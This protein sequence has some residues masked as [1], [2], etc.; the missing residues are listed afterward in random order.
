MSEQ[1][2]SPLN[3][4]IEIKSDA[5]S[6]HNVNYVGKINLRV[7]EIDSDLRNKISDFLGYELPFNN[8]VSGDN[9]T[10]TLWLG[11]NEYLILCED[12]EKF[13][14]IN[15]LRSNL[16][17]DFFA[18]TDVSDYYLTM[19]L[20]GQN[21]IDVL[22]KSCSLDFKLNVSEKDTCAQTYINKATVLIDR[23][24]EENIFDISVRWSFAEYLWEWLSDSC[25]EYINGN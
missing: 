21:A 2:N 7:N 1:I 20:S 9:K 15:D 19:R 10:R 12:N 5:I 23:L 6:L 14:I 24:S 11:P 8:K 4:K 25:R 17:S 3:D 13:N 22:S 18:I 16:G